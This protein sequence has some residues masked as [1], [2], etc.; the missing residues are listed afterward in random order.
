M[1]LLNR[2]EVFSRVLLVRSCN[3]VSGRL[4]G[5]EHA[6]LWRLGQVK[7]GQC[8]ADSGNLSS[9]FASFPVLFAVSQGP[10][11]QFNYFIVKVGLIMGFWGFGVLGF[12]G[13]GFRV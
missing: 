7:W 12:W 6:E 11:F 3:I 4:L 13:L 8:H 1:R 9:C 2:V 10:L 5:L